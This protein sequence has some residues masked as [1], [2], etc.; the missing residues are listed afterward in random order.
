[1]RKLIS[2]IIIIVIIISNLSPLQAFA[3]EG[4]S[5]A[6][7]DAPTPFDSPTPTP[8]PTPPNISS[9]QNNTIKNLDLGSL[10]E[11]RSADKLDVNS[12]GTAA[13]NASAAFRL[14]TV[15][16]NFSKKDFR[17]DEKI[18]VVV[19]NAKTKDLKL[20]LFDHNGREVEAIT[21]E[22]SDVDPAVIKIYPKT[23][24][25]PGRY[26]VVINDTQ[27]NTQ[28]T[29]EFTWG[30]LSINT[31]KSIYK[32]ND[33][34]KIAFAVLD[35][36]GSMVCD[37][38]LKLEVKKPD[39]SKILLS[40][41]DGTI[42]VNP[43]CKLKDYTPNPDYEADYTVGK[44]GLYDLKLS[45]TTKN[46]DFSIQDSFE[47]RDSVPLDVER[48]GPTRIYPPKTYP[49][50]FN[51][52]ANEDFEGTITETVPES[53]Q[54]SQPEGANNFSKV[55]KL[56]AA[57]STEIEDA[58]IANIRPP[59]DGKHSVTQDFGGIERDP[60]LKKKY[61]QYGVIGHD[62]VDFDLAF[63]T[64]V[65][66]VDD[67]T[68][69]R[70]KENSDYGTTI[71]IQHSWGKSYYGH[72][73]K[74][75]KKEGDHVSKGEQIALS[76]NTGLSSGPH[77]HFAIKPNKNNFENGFY[78][79]I[80]PLAYLKDYSDS[81]NLAQV[82]DNSH[83]VLGAT[84]D[85]RQSDATVSVQALTWEVKLKKGES[86]K[87][88]YNFKAP[89]ISPEFYL[90]GPLKFEQAGRTVFQEVR[91]WQI[92]ADAVAP[93]GNLYYGD[94][95]TPADK[96]RMQTYT[97]SSNTFG[98][99]VNTS[100]PGTASGD[101]NWVVAKQSPTRDE[102]IVAFEQDG[103]TADLFVVKC[104]GGCDAA[105]DY[106]S[107]WSNT[108][109]GP[110]L[111]CDGTAGACDRP[112]DVGYEQ[113]SGDAMVVYGDNAT[114]VSGTSSK[115]Y[116]CLYNGTSWSPQG[117]CTPTDGTNDLPALTN[118][119]GIPRWVR[120][121][122]Q[123]EQLTKNRTDRILV[124]A[125]TD[126]GDIGAWIWN[127]SN[128]TSLASTLVLNALSNAATPDQWE[129]MPFD[130][131]WETNSGDAI[132]LFANSATED[133]TP[134]AY[135]V[136]SNSG[137]TWDGSETAIPAV[138]TQ[139][140]GVATTTYITRWIDLASSP[141]SDIIIAGL[142]VSDAAAVTTTPAFFPYHWSGSAWN[143]GGG[144][145]NST[146][147]DDVVK[148]QMN[149]QASVGFEKY[150]NGTEFGIAATVDGGTT[151]TVRYTTFT[152]PS[153]WAALATA[154]S[155]TDDSSAV[156]LYAAPNAGSA[157]ADRMHLLARDW[158]CNGVYHQRWT[159]S[160]WDGGNPTTG[161]IPP[162][163]N[164]THTEAPGYTWVYKMYA[165][166]TN[167]WRWYN[168]TDLAPIPTTA[169][170]AENT[171]P[172]VG[173]TSGDDLRLRINVA[174]LGAL[175]ETDARKKLQYVSAATCSDPNSCA[176]SNWTDVDDTVGAGIWRYV[177]LSCTGGDPCA[178]GTLLT[179]T[180]LTGTDSTCSAGNGCGTWV[181][182]KNNAAGA[183]MDHNSNS[184]QSLVQEIE[185]DIENNGAAGNTVYYFRLFDVEDNTSIFRQQDSSTVCA[186]SSACTYPSIDTTAVDQIHYRWRSDDGN[187]TSGSSLQSEDTAHTNL[188]Q[189]TNIRLRFTMNSTTGT[190]STNYRLEWAT[191][192]G[193]SCDTDE[194]YAAVPDTATTEPFDMTT[195]SNYTDQGA[196][197][198]ASSGPGVMTDPGGSTFTAG[199]LV[200]SPSNSASSITLT[201]N[202]F[203]ELEYNF[204]ANSN[205]ASAGI[206]CF[207]LT[208]AGTPF[209]TYTR[210]PQVTM[211]T[212]GPTLDQLMRHGAW[213]NNGSEAPFTF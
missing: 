61:A 21:E 206:Y 192:V 210:Y 211:A 114:A 115:L 111:A 172:V 202:H 2:I 3:Q 167:N 95:D 157:G 100:L 141:S 102:Q 163:C 83:Q 41:T 112:F 203:T 73:S 5:S 138:S 42:K 66:A 47:V 183:N 142:G 88:G 84:T 175:S 125:M 179:G 23:R 92:A 40:T 15:I 136:Y 149:W 37:A 117:S 139:C 101:T 43:D 186:G 58:Q 122:P 116:Y 118:F 128:F 200:E 14:P 10:Y 127:G 69:V 70:A 86:I 171:R 72:L 57:P 158:D 132:V 121:I 45:A 25:I 20:K 16:K 74:M 17:A 35:E 166:W 104:T 87:L 155:T 91:E 38:T 133:T 82:V 19:E 204:Q 93:N 113:L 160:A 151:L 110:V 31:N 63:G 146:A 193:A 62:G 159:G 150:N 178:D 12:L 123:G 97:D 190:G 187:E 51:I 181:L 105:G 24:F 109:V 65:V 48:T 205:A 4:S 143:Q 99:E 54:V 106:S 1:M 79:K 94:L 194:T 177:D 64:P 180:V 209:S 174:N 129:T 124:L 29:Q 75:E 30:V 126:G 36:K 89:D 201:A 170:A 32:P 11:N 131:A 60:L 147:C 52:Y 207:R 8:T 153:T 18:T 120:V 103:T 44:S 96:L 145:G 176:D 34:A 55:T 90:L 33:T 208:N 6:K 173:N 148:T 188:A 169:L 78:G 80:D 26:R 196:S 76:G 152:A 22:I 137:N 56:L 197:T 130:G 13:A 154:F 77:L 168:G 161:F 195:T 164:N 199:Q 107:Q 189:N 9:N 67:G 85:V 140:S 191:R 182:D 7:S 71:I 156:D 50:N 184:S 185:Y 59:F 144:S 108:G 135:K 198:N 27:A 81:V 119:N 46:G 162:D 134:A 39:G 53:F 212:T 68:V 49:V 98:G 213:F 28:S 165:A